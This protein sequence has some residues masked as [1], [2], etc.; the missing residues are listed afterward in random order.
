[1]KTGMK[2]MYMIATRAGSDRSAV[3]HA[4]SKYYRDWGISI[5]SLGGSRSSAD[6]TKGLNSFTTRA[7]YVIYLANRE[8]ADKTIIPSTTSPNTVVHVVEKAKIR[9]MRL[10]EIRREIERARASLRTRLYYEGGFYKFKPS[11]SSARPLVEDPEVYHD[12]LAFRVPGFMSG[13]VGLKEGWYIA[14]RDI[15][16]RHII[17]S[18]G[19][20]AGFLRIRDDLG[21]DKYTGLQPREIDLE[22]TA[23]INRDYILRLV[24]ET[25]A[26]IRDLGS[27]DT[28]LV[29]WSG[30]KD[31]TFILQLAVREFGKS[32]VV[33]VFVDIDVDFPQ[34]KVLVGE[35]SE[36]L[37]VGVVVKRLELKPHLPLKG[38]PTHED[39]WCSRL[40]VSAIEEA[41]REVCPRDA[42]CLVL[43]GDRDVESESRSQKPPVF[44]RGNLTFAYPLKQWSTL[45]LQLASITL[46]V[47][48]NPLY[49]LGF[50]RIGCYICPSLRGWE[51]EI[52]K[53]SPALNSLREDALFKSFLEKRTTS[54]S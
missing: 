31:S 48:L 25:A 34:N 35:V 45:L 17:Y 26:W 9:N 1:M 27:F 10:E 41:Y 6:L 51:V 37:G 32:R 54:S 20:P 15:G 18:E 40:K 38:F 13:L 5:V 44:S 42:Q 8:D 4:V 47:T 3:E 50:Y 22:E 46:G 33:P 12:I 29:P 16:G 49:E 36:K 28:V 21:F 24:D 7:L 11:S 14:L 19:R 52:I 30:G 39:R 2:P 23:R 43:V 53:N